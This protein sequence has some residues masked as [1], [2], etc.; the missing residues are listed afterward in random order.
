MRPSLSKR[1]FCFVLIASFGAYAQTGSQPQ[2]PVPDQK[3]S[4]GAAYQ[5]AMHPLEIT[6]HNIANWSD[7]EIAAMEV[8]ISNAKTACAAR[9]PEDY[10]KADLID[11]ARLCALGQQWPLVVEAA[12]RYIAAPTESKALLTDAYTAKT[13][14]H[15]HMKQEPEGLA[16]ALA[17]LKAVPYS[18]EVSDCMA[19]ALDYMR[20]LYTADAI[21]LAQAREPL[22][23]AAMRAQVAAPAAGA[24]ALQTQ[25]MP[26]LSRLYADGLSLAILEQLVA[27]PADAEATFV[28]LNAALPATVP[29]DDTIRIAQHRR[30]YSFLGRPLVGVVPLRSLSSPANKVPEIP[31]RSTITALLLFPD[32]CAQC[33]RLGPQLPETVFQVEGHSAY[34]YALLVETVPARK[35]DPKVTNAAFSPSYAAAMLAETP[36]VTVAPETL[37]RFE[38]TDFPLLLITDAQGVVRV[39]Q[40]VNAQE[41]KPGGDIDSAIAL[42]GKTFGGSRVAETPVARSPK[43]TQ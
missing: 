33:V 5:D 37:T 29:P 28:A 17:M 36:T 4:P 18:A 12:D 38:A 20:F 15:L 24:S 23:L 32:W 10:T 8:A 40:P 34:V 43:A 7:I 9:K 35:P 22:V 30:Q 6:R 39:L 42:V 2:A 1:F 27:A 25:E 21:K 13:E 26:S 41:L 11:L 14:A 19:E 31:A 3:L 16:S